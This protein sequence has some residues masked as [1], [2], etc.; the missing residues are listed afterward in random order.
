[1][2]DRGSAKDTPARLDYFG[3][4]GVAVANPGPRLCLSLLDG[5]FGPQELGVLLPGSDAVCP[6]SD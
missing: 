5:T 6:A 1:M 3:G 4:K 2:R